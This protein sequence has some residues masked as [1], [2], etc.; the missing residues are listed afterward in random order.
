MDADP[1]LLGR[2]AGMLPLGYQKKDSQVDQCL[3]ELC[4]STNDIELENSGCLS[5]S[6][7]T[8]DHRSYIH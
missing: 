4:G 2:K 8:Y 3:V 7:E 1:S 6:R 5:L